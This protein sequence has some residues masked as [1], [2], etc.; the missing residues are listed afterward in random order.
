MG[1]VC[2]VAKTFVDDFVY[3]WVG[4][5]HIVDQLLYYRYFVVVVAIVIVIIIVIAIAIG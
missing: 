3:F 1:V 5:L 4:M 2:K